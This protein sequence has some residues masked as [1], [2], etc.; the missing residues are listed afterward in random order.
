MIISHAKKFIYLK[1]AKVAGTST[2]LFFERFC[3]KEQDIIGERATKDRRMP[4]VVRDFAWH[5]HKN[6]ASI[7]EALNDDLAWNTYLK[8]G[9]IRNPWD[10]V[11]SAYSFKKEWTQR[12]PADTSFDEYIRYMDD[13]HP[14]PLWDFYD[15]DEL[16]EDYKTNTQWIRFENLHEDILSIC[17]TLN[18]KHEGELSHKHKTSRNPDYRT[19]YTAETRRIVE[20]KYKKDIENY[21]YEY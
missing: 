11:V 5:A 12:I 10:R 4:E 20:D 7:K 17:N 2:E 21:G 3:D 13:E 1:G 18:L 15:S 14:K 6:P 19:Y 16:E 9:N 8:F